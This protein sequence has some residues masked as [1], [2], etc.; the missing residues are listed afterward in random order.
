[1]IL[2][3]ACDA[4]SFAPPPICSDSGDANATVVFTCELDKMNEMGMIQTRHIVLTTY[5]VY[6]FKPD[7]YDCAQ[8][9]KK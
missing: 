4:H 3:R 6:N 9:T 2:I 5:G 8:R 7:S 1:V